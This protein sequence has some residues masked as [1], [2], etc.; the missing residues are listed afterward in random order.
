MLTENYNG[1]VY[2]VVEKL[3]YNG[4]EFIIYKDKSSSK[5]N[6]TNY[7]INRI[8]A[9]NNCEKINDK[10]KIYILKQFLNENKITFPKNTPSKLTKK[11]INELEKNPNHFIK[12]I[13]KNN[14]DFNSVMKYIKNYGEKIYKELD[15]CVDQ[16]EKNDILNKQNEAQKAVNQVN[17]IALELESK[18]G[19]NSWKPTRWLNGK[20]TKL[21]NYLWCKMKYANYT[22]ETDTI[23]IF[24]EKDNNV[25]RIRFSLELYD[26]KANK[27]AYEKHH[28]FLDKI[29]T[30]GLNY[31]IGSNQDNNKAPKITNETA[32]QIKNKLSNGTYKKIQVSKIIDYDPNKTNDDIYKE[33]IDGVKKLIPFYEYV[34]GKNNNLYSTT[35]SNINTQLSNSGAKNMNKKIGLNTILYGPPGTG[36]TYNTKRYV[37]AICDNKSLDEV[38][39]QDYDKEIL[40]RFKELINE[41]RV[42]FTTFHQSYGYEEFI[43]GIRPSINKNNDVIYKIQSGIFKN[44]CDSKINFNISNKFETWLV[45]I[46]SSILQ[47][48]F[49]E[50]NIR[51]DIK[52]DEFENQMQLNDIVLSLNSSNE[53]NG[54]A[55]IKGNIEE[56]SD[57]SSFKFSRKVE[58]LFN[59]KKINIETVIDENDLSQENN[60]F[61]LNNIQN[62]K[63]EDLINKYTEKVLVIDEIN[64]GNISKIFGE[65]ITLIEESKRKGNKEEISAILPYSGEFFSVPN[66][67]YILGT[68][69]TADRSINLMDTALRRRF[70]FVEMMPNSNVLNNV[71][72]DNIDI[73]KMLDTINERITILFDREHT[74][75][76]AFFTNL[77]SNSK[78]D[79]LALIFKNKIIPLLQ[80]YFYEDYS[81]IRLVLGDTDKTDEKYKFIK[82]IK[83]SKEIFKGNYDID[84]IGEFKYELNND[85]FL[86]AE[87]YKQIY[88]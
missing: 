81:K 53:L 31:V 50:N 78:T 61:K 46:D 88:Q 71:T 55:L 8:S 74:I 64:R 15:K 17:L 48:C 70:N 83:N 5:K 16:N 22:S 73:K 67:L 14:I 75:G 1:I 86:E 41:N 45:K 56:L 77:K 63:I 84:L 68:M 57:K 69:N 24:V 4:T 6:N 85:A 59:Y 80:E 26:Q 10:L 30:P 21:R 43:E 82:E 47:D 62:N 44:F 12:E 37:V 52:N 87:S 23:S 79:D 27:V 39:N 25:P 29:L 33:M 58:W 11:L 34:I 49:N 32:D 9:N 40:P 51:V 72:V 28:K 38:Y 19:L 18:F 76:H 3:K 35:S 20:N 13:N 7:D 54:I 42:K 36:K 65:L 2:N 60:I 66:N